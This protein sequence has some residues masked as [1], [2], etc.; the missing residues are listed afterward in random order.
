[1]P[2]LISVPVYYV[3]NH[4]DE[5]MDGAVKALVKKYRGRVPHT[6]FGFGNRDL[7]VEFM[8]MDDVKEFNDKAGRDLPWL[9]FYI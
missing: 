1:M 4:V 9:R 2:N 8:N 6:G 5:S 7:V 3:H